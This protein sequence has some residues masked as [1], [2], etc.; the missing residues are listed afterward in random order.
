MPLRKSPG[1]PVQLWRRR[2]TSNGSDA[3]RLLSGG[4][5]DGSGNLR[6]GFYSISGIGVRGRPGPCGLW[7]PR[8][9]NGFFYADEIY[10][11]TL[12]F[13]NERSGRFRL[14]N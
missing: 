6:W 12:I 5:D 7:R 1:V 11:E 13:L 14:R 10:G 9:G 3:F 2:A 4:D 8:F